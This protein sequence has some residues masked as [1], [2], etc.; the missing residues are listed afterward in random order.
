MRGF[1]SAGASVVVLGLAG[2]SLAAGRHLCWVSDAQVES[3]KVGIRFFDPVAGA[4]TAGTTGDHQ[5]FIASPDGVT[6]TDKDYHPVAPKK[7]ALILGI[8]DRVFVSTIPEDACTLT[9]RDNNGAMVVEAEAAGQT[10]DHRP[11]SSR[12][13]IPVEHAQ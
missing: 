4:T 6:L 8:G 13:I 12:E 2:P 9:V 3:G 5:W 10:P 11:I 1:L 7:A